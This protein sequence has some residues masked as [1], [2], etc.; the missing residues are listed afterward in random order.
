MAMKSKLNNFL[1]SGYDFYSY[2]DEIKYKFIFINSVMGF[3]ALSV[4]FMGI[5]RLIG[6][7]VALGA[8]DVVFSLLTFFFIALMR[9]NREKIELFSNI[10][11]GITFTLFLA[12]FIMAPQQ[13]VRVALFFLFIT[14]TFFLKGKQSGFYSL[15]IVYFIVIGTHLSGLFHLNYTNLD[16]LSIFLYLTTFYFILCTYEKVKSIQHVKIVELIEGLEIEVKKRTEELE[17]AN[18][19]LVEEKKALK[20]ISQTDQLTGLYNRFKLEETFEYE[21]RQANRYKTEL[22]IVIMDI[23]YFKIVN[24]TYGHNEGDILLRTVSVELKKMFRDTDVVGRWGG[25]EFLIL[26]PKT[27]LEDAYS[28]IERLRKHIEKKEFKHIGNK[29]ASF[30]ITNLQENDTLDVAIGRAD[31]ALYDA[32]RNGRNQVKI[33]S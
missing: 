29:T 5:I 26:L 6:E 2:E 21:R 1:E 32:K 18:S 23:D 31:K 28:I 4:L 12:V 16:I 20:Q 19:K 7:N 10:M 11:L 9:K 13:P 22:S 14:A 25:E 33:A 15:I 3:A 8:V 27:A 24:D 30:G 17:V